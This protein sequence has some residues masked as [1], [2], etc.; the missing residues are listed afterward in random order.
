MNF[1]QFFSTNNWWG[2]ILGGFFGFLI[3]GST[4]ALFGIIIGNF[5]DR[6]LNEHFTNPNWRYHNEK[7][8][9]VQQIFFEA[10][11][12]VMGHIA[13]AD[14]RVSER[15]IQMARQMMQ[16]MRLSSAQKTLAKQ[17]Y[18]HG[19]EPNYDLSR[20]LNLLLDTC[21]D[22][23]DLLKLFMDI[24]YRAAQ[25]DG[26]TTAK[27]QALNVVFRRLGFVP[28]N[29]QY[30]F[31]E[32][33]GSGSY[34]SSQQSSQQRSSSGNRYQ[35]YGGDTTLANAFAVL[36]VPST[37]TKQEVK[38]AYRRLIS[39]NHP[40]KLIAQGLPE[41]MIK[42]ANDKTQKITKAYDQICTSKGWN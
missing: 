23:R 21:R 27:I 1:R 12:T 42:M 20:I 10:T 2:K 16:E 41:E 28:L 6:G 7:R 40:D 30:R 35:A 11:F 33:F 19:K 31:Y 38:R 22:N 9:A 18:T 5:F 34:S 29:E 25:V 32:D 14:G 36:E 39:R 26:L 3:G 8:Q 37:A 17:Y 15:E 4:G 13:K 24:Q